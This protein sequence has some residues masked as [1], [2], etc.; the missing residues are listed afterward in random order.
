MA[1][2]K[3][4]SLLLS[5]RRV[6]DRGLRREG[7]HECA[8]TRKGFPGMNKI[9]KYII[10]HTDTGASMNF[11]LNQNGDVVANDVLVY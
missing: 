11:K 10:W 1:N 7:V 3:N 4:D 6:A 8:H 2:R 9:T 5:Q